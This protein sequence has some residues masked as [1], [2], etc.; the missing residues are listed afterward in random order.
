MELLDYIRLAQEYEK[1]G[2]PKQGEPLRLAIVTNFTDDLLKKAIIGMC[3]AEGIRPDLYQ[4]PFKQYLFELKNPDSGLA[5]H[6]ADIV[7]VF[8]DINPYT[9]SEF[10]A[11]VSHLHDV[12]GDIERYAR[13]HACTVV[14]HTISAPS[15]LQHGRILKEDSFSG[16]I[17]TYNER[18]GAIA[19]EHKNVSV[20]DA[21]RIIRVMGER[22]ARD[23]RGLYA[24]SHPWSNDFIFALAR[25]WMTHIRTM[26]GVVY[27]CIVLDLDNTLWGGIVGET[28][29]LGIELGTEYPGNAY[30]EFQRVLL[31]YHERGV[32][33]AVNSRNNMA[34]VDEV[35][36]KNPHMVL[37]KSHFASLAVNWNTKAENLPRIAEELNIGLSSMI[38]IDDDPVNRDLVRAQLPEV[39]VPDWNMPPEEYAHALLNLDAFHAE[40]LTE[41]DL[42]RGAMYAAERER[43]ALQTKAPTLEEYLKTLRIE[44]TVSLNAAVLI[45]RVAQLTQKTNQFNLSTR[46]STEKEIETWIQEGG[47][48]F[49]GDVRDTFGSYGVTVVAI[50]RPVDAETATLTTLLMSCRVMGRGVEHAFLRAVAAELQKRGF[51]RLTIPFIQSKKNAP[52]ADFLRELGAEAAEQK[53]SGETLY[54]LPLAGYLSSAAGSHS[55]IRVNSIL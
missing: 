20:L 2:E 12:L 36:D 54:S 27:K 11:D 37:K 34:D 13:A 39:L 22:R 28:G 17:R 51:A 25:E 16:L 1:G 49:T 50:I 32:I 15:S 24:F 33:L 47:L 8:F 9:V 35:F 4:V 45:T 10:S 18:L 26:R 46:R 23:L 41:E 38:F 6:N 29:P 5:K 19:K 44:L 30:R 42:Q 7:F 52:A 14:V 48:V 40:M 53:E 55:S 3:A 31:Q 43:K 21:G